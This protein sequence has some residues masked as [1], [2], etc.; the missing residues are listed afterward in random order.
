MTNATIRRGSKFCF[1]LAF[2][3]APSCCR[4]NGWISGVNAFRQTPDFFLLFA[5]IVLVESIV[6][7]LWFKPIRGLPVLWRVVVLN[8]ASSLAGDALF[9]L[10]L[11]P[12][13]GDLWKQAIPFFF[14]TI[15][16]ECPLMP[17][18]LPK[19]RPGWKRIVTAGVTINML[20]YALLLA[21]DRPVR[22]AWLNQLRSR[23][24]QVLAQWTNSQMLAEAPG[25]IYATGSAPGEPHRLKYFD[26]ADL[27]WHSVSN[28]PSIDPRHWH[29]EGNLFAFLTYGQESTRGVV[30]LTT[31]PDCAT[32]RDLRLPATSWRYDSGWDVAISPDRTKLAV[33]VPSHEIQG[34]LSGS[35]YQVL[36]KTCR[37]AVF[38]IATGEMS[39]CPRQASHTLCW[40]PDS[41]AVLFHSLREEK[42]HELTTLPKG[43][44]KKYDPRKPDSPF[45]QTPLFAFRIGT[46]VVEPFR[47]LP[48]PRL[49]ADANRLAFASG[50]DA[51]GLLDLASDTTSQ[52]ILGPMGGGTA[53]TL[54]PDARFALVPLV[55]NRPVSYW[56]HPTIVDLSDPS[57]RFYFGPIPYRVLWARTAARPPTHPSEVDPQF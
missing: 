11:A 26:F 42:L 6:F 17:L 27:Q 48:A 55:L 21:I 40:L 53:L 35:S 33:L 47:D 51:L 29:V 34:P 24:L 56:G 30:R 12:A 2:V 20:S 39:I 4:A 44:K 5:A 43:W 22:H 41:R 10:G 9:R 28:S 37:L 52:I 50:T 23:D 13:S 57:R 18:L 54:S 19:P 3:L 31:L 45:Q 36:G 7:W 16:V 25:R 14:L 8:A 32:I 1:V 46:G 38:D 15:A 49:A